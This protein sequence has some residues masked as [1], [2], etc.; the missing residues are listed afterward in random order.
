MRGDLTQGISI[1]DQRLRAHRQQGCKLKVSRGSHGTPLQPL[2][3]LRDPLKT[4]YNPLRTLLGPPDC[5]LQDLWLS[6]SYHL[7]SSGCVGIQKLYTHYLRTL[8]L[9]MRGEG[10]NRPE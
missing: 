1:L 9:G 8:F 10:G 6:G 4:Q 3:D 2:E 7:R 5:G